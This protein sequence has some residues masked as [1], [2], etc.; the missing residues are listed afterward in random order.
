MR[1]ETEI[2]DLLLTTA[3]DDE[4]IRA[5]VL[6]GSR[7]NP[8]VE[9]DHFQDFDLIY[10]VT[11]IGPF[12]SN[13]D[14]IDRFSELMIL[15]TPDL[16]GK[17]RTRADDGFTWLMQF[18]D[19]N[20]ID[21]TLIP[22]SHLEKMEEDSLSVLLLDKDGLFES[23]PAPSETSYLPIP[24]TAKA[25]FDCCNE[26]W[27]VSPYVAKALARGQILYAK[28]KLD[29]TL[30]VQLMKV[31]TWLF[32][33]HTD[34]QRNPGKSNTHL[35]EVLTEAQWQQLLATYTPAEVDATWDAL[36][37]MGALFREVAREVGEASGFDYPEKEDEAVSRYLL[38]IRDSL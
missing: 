32:G 35:R 6:N 19:G 29:D 3:L 7:V 37:A 9:P 22:I 8:N 38:E 15:Q 28:Q 2:M 5:V 26:F 31:L 24:P 23:F 27:W 14:W 20:R 11:E 1:S 10:V 34:F 36:F 21:L 4:H 13:H 17:P 16:I 12:L 18:M 33:I 30:R 25:F